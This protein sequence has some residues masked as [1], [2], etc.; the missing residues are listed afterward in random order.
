MGALSSNTFTF[1]FEAL[2][3]G[4]DAFLLLWRRGDVEENSD[5]SERDEGARCSMYEGDAN[6]RCSPFSCCSHRT[7]A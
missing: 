5:G 3:A 4:S 2:G 7:Q 1:L 6:V